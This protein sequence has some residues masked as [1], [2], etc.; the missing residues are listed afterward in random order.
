MKTTL[1]QEQLA[2]SLNVTQQA[3]SLRLDAM[4]KIQKEGKWVPY[5]LSER[6]KEQ[7]KTKAEILLERFHRKSFLHRIVTG[8]EKWIYFYNP[9]RKRSWVSPGQPATST[10]K[11]NI[12]GKKVLL[13]VWWDQRGILYYELLQPGE[14]VTADRYQNQ[15]E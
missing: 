10:A 4:G 3:V 13:C 12:H 8:D 1:K 9:K 11:P 15:L 5:E 7:R 2:A 6:N 14:T